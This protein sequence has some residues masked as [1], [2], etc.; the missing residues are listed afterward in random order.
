M[1]QFRKYN[2]EKEL[3]QLDEKYFFAFSKDNGFSFDLF[4]AELVIDHGFNYEFEMS[5]FGKEPYI[6]KG[7]APPIIQ[8]Y[9]E[10]L[11]VLDYS[12]LKLSYD[13]NHPGRN[14]QGGSQ[15]LINIEED[16]TNILFAE[17]P[18]IEHFKNPTEQFF[19][20]FY[21]FL[22]NWIE[23]KHRSWIISMRN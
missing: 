9:L 2:E 12:L 8:D 22:S 6:E 3:I 15:L 11:I 5:V 17:E 18:I 7:I 16:S 4:G 21:Q 10:D 13:Y 20:S 23:E 1:E 19:Y 14:G